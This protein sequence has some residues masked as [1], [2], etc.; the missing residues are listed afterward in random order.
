[1][2][3]RRTTVSRLARAWSNRD[4]TSD[5]M[6]GGAGTRW[7]PRR[8]RTS[9]ISG[10]TLGVL[11]LLGGAAGSAW[12]SYAIV[13]AST[14]LPQVDFTGSV[15]VQSA[16]KNDHFSIGIR[17]FDSEAA[18]R[19]IGFPSFEHGRYM[20]VNVSPGLDAKTPADGRFAIV[21]WD[22]AM[23]SDIHASS[24]VTTVAGNERVSLAA[25]DRPGKTEFSPPVDLQ[26]VVGQFSYQ[27]GFPYFEVVGRL[28]SPISDTKAGVTYLQAPSISLGYE[29][30][31]FASFGLPGT[32]YTND[33]DEAREYLGALPFDTEIT[34]SLP[35]LTGDIVE[36]SSDSDPPS[37]LQNQ[38]HASFVNRKMQQQ[39]GTSLFIGGALAGVAGG[40]FVEMV[41]RLTTEDRRRRRVRAHPRLV[42]TDQGNLRSA[43]GRLAAA[44][45]QQRNRSGKRTK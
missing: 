16:T 39:A 15:A 29:E 23:L 31:S 25:P 34:T 27:K 4:H 26:I 8:R 17:F 7:T 13:N 36:W 19:D 41:A 32:W 24:P 1:M 18:S 42:S 33:Y 28:R 38:P 10:S 45:R 14:T 21:L 37:D 2:L 12:S 44:R 20:E 43:H 35:S 30:A 3:V 40:F 11:I 22:D 9:R 5:L 6:M